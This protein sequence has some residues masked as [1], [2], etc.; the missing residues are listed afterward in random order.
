[1]TSADPYV[2]IVDGGAGFWQPSRLERAGQNNVDK[3]RIQ[4]SPAAPNNAELL[5]QLVA[6][7]G[8]G[9]TGINE[10]FT[11]PV[12]RGQTIGGG[13]SSNTTLTADTEYIVTGNMV[14]AQGVT[15]TIQRGAHPGWRPTLIT[16][17]DHHRRRRGW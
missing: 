15:L 14:V 3:I 16:V 7:A 11:V 8:N 2:T 17:Q 12:R 9:G 13:I 6:T 1:M 4:I 10:S 5:L